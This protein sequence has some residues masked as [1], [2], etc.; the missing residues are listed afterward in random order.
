MNT[1]IKVESADS[2]PEKINAADF[3][4]KFAKWAEKR[5][6]EDTRWKRTSF[7]KGLKKKK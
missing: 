1:K 2:K 6:Q 7:G 5:G 3:N 4:A